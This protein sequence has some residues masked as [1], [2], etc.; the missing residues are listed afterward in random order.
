MNRTTKVRRTKKQPRHEMRNKKFIFFLIYFIVAISV[1]CTLK[2][3]TDFITEHIWF[4]FFFAVHLRLEQKVSHAAQRMNDYNN[5]KKFLLEHTHFARR[6]FY[7]S[8]LLKHPS[9]RFSF[10]S[11]LLIDRTKI[12]EKK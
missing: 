5:N 9:I 11:S 8:T 2:K 6:L 12:K 1:Q 3:L 4:N 10:S 7:K